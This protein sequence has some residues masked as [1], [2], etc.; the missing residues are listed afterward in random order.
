MPISEKTKQALVKTMKDKAEAR[1]RE[2]LKNTSVRKS[3]GDPD[4]DGGKPKI[5]LAKYIRG[6][7]RGDWSNADVE[8]KEFKA[9]NKALAEGI[10]YTGGFLVPV[11]QNRELIELIRAK[12][13]VRGM[14]G[15]R[16]YSMNS[17]SMTMPRIDTGT[18]G[19]WG[20]EN[21]TIASTA[22]TF[23]QIQLVLRKRVGKVVMSNELIEDASPAVEDL[24]RRDLVDSIA[25]AVDLAYLEGTGGEQPTGIYNQT[26]VNS[27]DLSGTPGYDDLWNAIY[28]IRLQN[29]EI[30]GWVSHPR[31]ENTLRKLK[32]GN[33]LYIYDGIGMSGSVS[34]KTPSLLGIP[35]SYTTNIPITLR[36]ASNE[37]Y[38]IGADWSQFIIGEK[39]TIKLEASRDEQFSKDQTVVRA[40]YRTDCALRHPEAFVVVKGIQA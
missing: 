21:E 32:D 20:G 31:L 2:H 35:I 15:V 19:T 3:H 10:G 30:N 6:A 7:I 18:S 22:A 39:G 1:L 27:T 16:T 34:N 33:G 23:G 12:T 8:L 14:P 37:S 24:I 28:R 36:P 40:V 9:V 11:E 5:S 4:T 29:H 38:L 26:H 17:N 25:L 13:V